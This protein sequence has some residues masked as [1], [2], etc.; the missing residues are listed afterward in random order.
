MYLFY[1]IYKA[2][3]LTQVTLGDLQR[4]NIE[5]SQHIVPATKDKQ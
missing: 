5:K 4:L 3:H 1:I 2:A